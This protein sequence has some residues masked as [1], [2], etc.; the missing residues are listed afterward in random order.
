[1]GTP[2]LPFSHHCGPDPQS[3]ERERPSSRIGDGGCFS[4][5]MVKV[6]G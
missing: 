4:A 5:M 3:P 6:L 1:M 2:N